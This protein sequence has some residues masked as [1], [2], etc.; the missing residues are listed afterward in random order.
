[1]RILHLIFLPLSAL[2]CHWNFLISGSVS[3]ADLASFN[4]SSPSYFLELNQDFLEKNQDSNGLSS[5]ALNLNLIPI[6]L[7]V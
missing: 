2:Q 6:D 7:A 3:E 1:M 4:E 5:N